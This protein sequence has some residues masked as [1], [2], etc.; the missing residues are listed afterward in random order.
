MKHHIFHNRMFVHNERQ[1]LVFQGED[2][3]PGLT[4]QKVTNVLLIEETVII[5][6]RSD[7]ERFNLSE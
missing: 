7:I 5:E 4:R 6:V 1:L 3:Q 2:F